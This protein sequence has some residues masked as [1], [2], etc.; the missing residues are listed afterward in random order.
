M[1]KCKIFLEVVARLQKEKHIDKQLIIEKLIIIIFQYLRTDYIDSIKEIYVLFEDI[2][3][4]ENLAE[5]L[6]ES[7]KIIHDNIEFFQH[8]N[9][10]KT[11]AEL[12]NRAENE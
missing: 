8:F 11:I 10:K 1:E 9:L 12:E 6:F 5:H 7:L 3:I 2:M 4:T